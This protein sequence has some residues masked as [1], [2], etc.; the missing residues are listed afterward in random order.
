MRASRRGGSNASLRRRAPRSMLLRYVP[1]G[2]SLR[3]ASLATGGSSPSSCSHPTTT[4]ALASLA[5][6]TVTC[7]RSKKVFLQIHTLTSFAP[8]LLNR[9]DAGLAKRV[10][11]GNAE[12]MRVSSQCLK[13]HWRDELVKT[14]DLPGAIRS[15]LFFE[16]EVLP[17]VMAAGIPE[18]DA[19]TLVELLLRR[20]IQGGQDKDRPLRLNQ[21]ILFGKPEADYF[22]SMITEA[23]KSSDA[24]RVLTEKLTDAKKNLKAMMAAA[25]L[26]SAVH[27]IEG[28]MFG[29][30]VTSDILARSDA[31]VHV[32]HA[33]TVHPLQSEIDYFTV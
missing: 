6:S 21:P 18:A 22:I 23:A 26:G 14:T 4:S 24:A 1:P 9:D 19:T 2:S 11:F 15:R 29:R 13:K 28:A 31:A 3:A 8:A 30:F 27:G 16:R 5:T 17:R 7:S 20:V 33:I 12:R 25:G 32:A 10:P